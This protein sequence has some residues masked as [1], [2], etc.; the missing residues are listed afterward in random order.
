MCVDADS[1]RRADVDLV[2]IDEDDGV[3]PASESRN[4][5][6]ERFGVWFDVTGQ[7][8]DEVRGKISTES[9]LVHDTGPVQGIAVGQRR[10]AN[11][12][13]DIFDQFQRPGPGA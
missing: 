8:G 12:T 2:V 11:V 5:V 4:G 13:P 9:H 6:F 1:P 3:R 7:V 10:K